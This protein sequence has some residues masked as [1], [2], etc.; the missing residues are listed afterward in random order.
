MTY[1]ASEQ[2]KHSG[3]PVELYRYDG[4]YA[5]FRYTSGPVV[6]SFQ[7]PDEAEPHDYIPIATRRSAVQH[8]T[9]NDDTAEVTIDLPVTSELVAVYGFQIAPPSLFLTIFRGHNP[10]EFVRY[11]QGNVENIQVV[12]GTATVRVPSLLA[13]ALSADVPNVYYQTPCNHTLFSPECGVDQADWMAVTSIAAVDGLDIT[14]EAGEIAAL[15]GD[16]VGGDAILASGERRMIVS[17][18]GDVIRVSYPFAGANVD[19]ELTVLAGCDL[20]LLG[21]C[22]NKFDNTINNGSFPFIPSKNIFQTGLE[23]GMSVEDTACLPHVA[24]F[25]GWYIK[26][27]ISW[28]NPSVAEPY[29]GA[30]AGTELV[31]NLGG[32]VIVPFEYIEWTSTD[33]DSYV[34]GDAYVQ[35]Q[36]SF[37][38]VDG[39][40]KGVVSYRRW[41]Q[42][43]YTVAIPLPGSDMPD[44]GGGVF[45]LYNLFPLR[46][47]FNF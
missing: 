17:Q 19:D 44:E 11:W 23:P 20:A 39:G 14:V 16:L 24:V 2:S 41:D 15:D 47:L 45:G 37:G 28:I 42:A 3:K 13:A 34:S 38:S 7:A 18:T 46:Q 40:M 36:F 5:M 8:T 25:E 21:D 4:T 22:K 9:Q 43:D 27:R 35:V 31:T 33:P 32:R 12:K 30:E 29:L 10:G 6:V 26:V 1:A